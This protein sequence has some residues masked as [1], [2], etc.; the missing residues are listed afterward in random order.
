MTREQAAALFKS[1]VKNAKARRLPV[2]ITIDDLLSMWR[3]TDGRC[4]LCG[5]PFD[6][7]R[8]GRK[9]RPFAPSVDRI[10]C[11][12]GYALDNC[13]L[14]C[15]AVNYAMSDW[16][17]GVLRQIAHGLL[18][19]VG[20]AEGGRLPGT[21]VRHRRGKIVFEVFLQ[22][23]KRRYLGC[24]DDE[25][26]AHQHYLAAK[27]AALRGESLEAFLPRRPSASPARGV[28]ASL[29]TPLSP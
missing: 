28:E 23:G 29:D 20:H 3:A 8:R 27:A 26:A 5:I 21:Y 22:R 18:G 25:R 12:R 11:S 17:E 19:R 1:I 2:E 7:A 16:G 10:D 9:R 24:F 15:V 4:A 13:R 6:F 14:V